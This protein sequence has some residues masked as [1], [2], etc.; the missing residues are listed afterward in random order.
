MQIHVVAGIAFL[1]VGDAFL[2]PV[3]TGVAGLRSHKPYA[4]TQRGGF[5]GFGSTPTI[6]GSRRVIMLFHHRTDTRQTFRRDNLGLVNGAGHRRGGDAGLLCDVG[7]K[8]HES[9]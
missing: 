7:D 2:K 4:E 8:H 3:E 6:E 5:F 9:G 1:H